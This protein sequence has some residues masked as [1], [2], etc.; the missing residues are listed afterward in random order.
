MSRSGRSLCE[1]TGELRCHRMYSVLDSRQVWGGR[2]LNRY[3]LRGWVAGSIG[4]EC[5]MTLFSYLP[6]S[7][8]LAPRMGVGLLG[9]PPFQEAYRPP[10]MG[11]SQEAG[12]PSQDA[13][14]MGCRPPS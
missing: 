14:I 11:A 6:A 5:R 10:G 12:H 13:G 7:W 1:L 2:P 9:C 4:S 3:N 8:Y